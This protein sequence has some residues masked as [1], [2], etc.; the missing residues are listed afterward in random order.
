MR[1]FLFQDELGFSSNS[2]SMKWSFQDILK[3]THCFSKCLIVMIIM[4]L[5]VYKE[6]WDVTVTAVTSF[7]WTLNFLSLFLCS[8]SVSQPRDKRTTIHPGQTT[9]P[10]TTPAGSRAKSTFLISQPTCLCSDLMQKWEIKSQLIF[11][12]AITT[13]HFECQ[14][15]VPHSHGHIFRLLILSDST[16]HNLK[17]MTLLSHEI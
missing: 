17:E 5:S 3:N 11:R 13:N 15:N 6:I 8:P 9:I 10:W 7:S 14:K 12:T 4:C 1:V 16:V 2:F